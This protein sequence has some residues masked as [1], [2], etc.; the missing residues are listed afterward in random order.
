MDPS[1][2]FPS[3]KRQGAVVFFWSRRTPVF[4]SLR[5]RCAGSHGPPHDL[6][7]T[8]DDAPFPYFLFPRGLFKS[9]CAYRPTWACQVLPPA[10]SEH[11]R[12]SD[13][14][15]PTSL[16]SGAAFPSLFIATQNLLLVSVPTFQ[17]QGRGDFFPP[18]PMLTRRRCLHYS[19]T[20]IFLEVFLNQLD[21]YTSSKRCVFPM[22]KLLSSPNFA[23]SFLRSRRFPSKRLTW[24]FRT[25]L[26][27][28]AFR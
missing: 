6:P 17:L 12:L 2:F 25:P 21:G 3:P 16:P 15:A 8:N 9:Y 28:C 19:R 4:M 18:P 20:F 5:G 11:L 22:A 10:L 27:L 13:N 23:L 26:S 24:I 14:D 1:P 7:L